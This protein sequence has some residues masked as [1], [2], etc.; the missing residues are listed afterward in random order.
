MLRPVKHR[1]LTE[2]HV[3]VAAEDNDHTMHWKRPYDA[4]AK[5]CARVEFYRQRDAR[6]ASAAFL[7]I[8]AYEC[9]ASGR[10]EKRVMLTLDAAAV[11]ELRKLLDD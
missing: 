3:G 11:D 6:H 1:P 8:N 9:P 10:G 4:N 2:G 5:G 7:S